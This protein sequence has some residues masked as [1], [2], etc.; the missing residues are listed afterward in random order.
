MK[1]TKQHITQRLIALT[2][3]HTDKRPHSEKPQ[4]GACSLGYLLQQV[5]T[6]VSLSRV[7]FA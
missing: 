5:A 2:L 7:W 3:H 1:N 6:N 4:I